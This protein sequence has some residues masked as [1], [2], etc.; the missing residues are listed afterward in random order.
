MHLSDFKSLRVLLLSVFTASSAVLLGQ[1]NFILKEQLGKAWSNECVSF[2]MNASHGEAAAGKKALVDGSGNQVVYQV[3]GG[4]GQQ[5]ISF[6]TDLQAY[7]TK[8]L[9]FGK[10]AAVANTDLKVTESPDRIRIENTYIGIELQ[11]KLSGDGGP[12]SKIRLRSGTWTG[13]STLEGNGGIA[14]IKTTLDAKGPVF[15]EATCNVTFKDGGT[16]TLTFRVEKQEPAVI[17]NEHYDAPSGGVFNLI[18]GDGAFKP[19]HMLMRDS[20]AENCSVT[21]GGIGGYYLEPWMHW[22]N[23]GHGSALGLY[24]ADQNTSSDMLAIGL[25]KPAAWVDPKWS[26]KAKQTGSGLSAKVADGVMTV[27]MPVQGGRRVWVLGALDKA[28]S[29]AMIG[30]RAA[31]PPHKLIVKHGSIPLNEVKDMVLEWQGDDDNHPVLW[32]RKKDIADLRTRLKS[33]PKELARW[34]SQQPVDKYLLEGP[35]KEFFATGDATLGK[36]MAAKAEEYLQIC[37]DWYLTQDY[38]HNPGTAPHMQ[39]LISTVLNLIDPVLS[40]EAFTPEARKRVLAKLAFIGYMTGSDDYWSPERGFSGFAN[41]TSIVALYRASLG[42]MLPNHPMAKAWADKGLGQHRWQLYAWSD[43]EGGCLEAPH[44]AMVSLDHMIAS[45]TMAANAGLDDYAFDPRLRKIYEWFAHISTPL[46]S[47]TQNTRHQPPIGNTYVG[48]I[49]GI[50]GMAA[51][52]WKEKDPEFAAQ[53][54]WVYEQMGSSGGL[55]I[56]WNFPSTVGYRW[57]MGQTGLSPKPAKFGSAKFS[58]T[59]VVLRNTMNT[60]R[61]TYLHMIAG[62]NHDHYD[63]DSG[64]IV[65]YGKGRVLADDWGYIGR[66]GDHWHSMVTGSDA[67]GGGIMNIEDFGTSEGL[68]YVTGKK[69]AW[70]RSIVFSKDEDP[71]GPNFFV[72]KDEYNAD[73]QAT[74]KLW[75]GPRF[76]DLPDSPQ[77]ASVTV[78]PYGATLNGGEDVDMDIFIYKASELGLKTEDGQQGGSCSHRYG[79]EGPYQLKQT[80]LLATVPA[81]GKVLSLLYPRLK[82]EPAPKVTWLEDGKVVQIEGSF[83]KDYLFLAEK[84]SRSQETVKGLEPLDHRVN[85]K[86]AFGLKDKKSENVPYFMFNKSDST[87]TPYHPPKSVLVHPGDLDPVTVAWRSPVSGM[88]NISATVSDLDGRTDPKELDKADGLIV[89]LRKSKQTLATNTVPEGATNI[90][91]KASN[92]I[93]KPGELVRLVVL[94][95]KCTWWDSSALNIRIETIDR[96]R[97]WDLTESMIKGEQL[98]NEWIGD[99]PLSPWWAFKGD[100]EQLEPELIGMSLAPLWNVKASAES[101]HCASDYGTPMM[102][103]VR[104]NIPGNANPKDRLIIHPGPRNPATLVWRSP[105]AG[106]VSVKAVIRDADP[107]KD[108]YPEQWRRDGVSYRIRKDKLIL[109]KGEVENGG[110]EVNV[111]TEKIEVATGDII[112]LSVYPNYCEWWDSTDVEMIVTDEKGKTW[113]ARKDILEGQRLGN[114]IGGDPAKAVWWVCEGDAAAFKP[115]MLVAPP[116]PELQ[117]DGGK[118]KFKGILGS[119]QLRSGKIRMSLGDTGQIK[120]GKHQLDSDGPASKTEAQ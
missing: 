78:T 115:S 103:M 69:G 5:K 27:P 58:N 45:F 19:T 87:D 20:R 29:L 47:R 88:I 38:L 77:S 90:Q 64:S 34:S 102:D 25:M 37:V 79:K 24:Y 54:L 39:S 101:I 86:E 48:E 63:L 83:G 44:Y 49:S 31:P 40:T 1:D 30:K 97:H 92:V 51:A 70:K 62:N 117:A 82:T 52:A 60:D 118:I 80:A 43:P 99:G 120:T 41:M 104:G 93:I 116:L 14:S 36:R 13:G 11:K 94:P 46:D 65:I 21:S 9:S 109:A 35:I 15:A 7:E 10:A 59:G 96:T 100:G 66:H 23:G 76:P 12:I 98:A 22:N 6:Q 26:G 108:D 91:I 57:T 18:L 50:C 74:W 105:V 28:E 3:A 73:N 55:G 53:M 71:L 114:Q 32:I 111:Q 84:P 4:K 119:V 56:G 42:C 113:D 17:V 106:T 2:P 75:L 112:R 110:K 61:E 16:W 89:E 107:G 81:R 33:D 85:S 8:T 68:D 72:I 95:G 67:W